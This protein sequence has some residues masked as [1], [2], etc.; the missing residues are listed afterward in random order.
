MYALFFCL[1]AFILRQHCLAVLVPSAWNTKKMLFDRKFDADEIVERCACFDQMM[2]MILPDG[3]H[4]FLWEKHMPGV[5]TR[6]KKV[7]W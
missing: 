6:F 1:Y 5:L 7:N 4:H 3:A 2:D